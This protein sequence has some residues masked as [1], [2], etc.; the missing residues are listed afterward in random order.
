M[1]MFQDFPLVSIIVTTKN[2][3]EVIERFLESVIKQ[4][5]KST[6]LILVDNNSSDKTKII[7]RKF[8]P[9][10]FNFGPERSSQ[11]N[12]GASKARGKYLLFLDADMELT[13][14]VVEKCVQLVSRDSKLGGIVIPEESVATT[15]WERVKAFERSFYNLEGDQIVEAARFFSREAFDS[16]GGY[17]ETITGPED[18]DLTEMVKNKGWKIGRISSVIYHHENIPSLWWLGK[19]KYYYALKS[20]RYFK[21][22]KISLFS[23]KSLYLL[24]PTFWKN[25]KRFLRHPSLAL[26]MILMFIVE[27]TGGFLG[28]WKGKKRHL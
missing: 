7:G 3:E 11:R 27:T 22:Q 17:D 26:G 14:Q 13:P 28:Y 19:K 1:V 15:Y 10:V 18:W 5:Y 21:K 6:E 2:E 20:H 9:K 4:T 16:V 12:F 23:P 25:W 24:R 8:T